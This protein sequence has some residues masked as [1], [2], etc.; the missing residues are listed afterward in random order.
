[1]LTWNVGEVYWPWHGNQLKDRDVPYV[2]ETLRAIDAD[3]VL[4]QELAHDGQLRAICGETYLGSTPRCCGYDRHVAVLVRASLRPTFG[5]A[6]LEPTT[7][8]VVWADLA[9]HGRSVRAVSLHFDVFNPG[10]RLAQARAAVKTFATDADLVVAGGDLNY[11]PN[12]SRRLHRFVDAET[13]AVLTGALVD[14][15][16]GSGPTLVGLLRVD[17][18]FAGGPALGRARAAVAPQR[19]KLGDHA[20]LVCALDIAEVDATS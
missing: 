19:T 10:R 16:E 6:L 20:P 4:L 3:V 9:F 2:A 18:I 17:R 8:G 1:M 15:A 14:V 11:D 13:E 12:A 5:E 7:R